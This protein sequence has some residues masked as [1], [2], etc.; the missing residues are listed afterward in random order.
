MKTPLSNIVSTITILLLIA[1][2]NSASAEINNLRT[3]SISLNKNGLE[4][5]YHVIE[6]MAQFKGGDEALYSFIEMNLKIP[7]SNS[8][9]R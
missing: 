4:K 7:K 9:G 8:K 3:D 6:Q 2:G 1:I 5:I